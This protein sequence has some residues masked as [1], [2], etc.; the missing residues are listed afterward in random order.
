MDLVS[1]VEKLQDNMSASDGRALFL[2]ATADADGAARE[3]VVK[4]VGDFCESG[5]RGGGSLKKMLFAETAGL[6]L[7]SADMTAQVRFNGC[8]LRLYDTSG[9]EE[10][11]NQR[12]LSTGFKSTGCAEVFV[13]V[14]DLGRKRT[15]LNLR[16]KWIPEIV[17][18]RAGNRFDG[19]HA[20]GPFVATLQLSH[21][22]P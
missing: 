10:H 17:R 22:A 9:T 15:L 3:M 2:A 20:A 19:R 14:F 12:F 13:L 11:E 21:V 4:F 8:T 18:S 6:E 7:S 5:A 1:S 16:Q